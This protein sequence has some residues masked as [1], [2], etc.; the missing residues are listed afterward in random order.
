M[1]DE[2][3]AANKQ[4]DDKDMELVQKDRE[5]EGLMMYQE[6]TLHY[7]DEYRSSR[8]YFRQLSTEMTELSKARKEEI[9]QIKDDHAH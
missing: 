4:R 3:T 7:L 8:D 6:E 5:C 2:I 9:E 1:K